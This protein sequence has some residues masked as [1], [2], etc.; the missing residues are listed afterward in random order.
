[1]FFVTTLNPPAS[2][3]GGKLFGFSWIG[4]N[5]VAIAED[6]FGYPKSRT[7]PPP[8]PTTLAHELRS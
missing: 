1:M 3:A 2:Q 4:N 8:R 6:V 5:G 7:S